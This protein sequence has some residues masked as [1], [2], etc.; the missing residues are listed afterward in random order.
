MYRFSTFENW[1]RY[2]IKRAFGVTCKY[3][4]SMYFIHEYKPVLTKNKFLLLLYCSPHLQ[5]T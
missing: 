2:T 3:S 4:V 1:R 5:L